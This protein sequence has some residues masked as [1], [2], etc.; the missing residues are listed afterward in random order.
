LGSSASRTIYQADYR[1]TAANDTQFP[2]LTVD[3]TGTRTDYSYDSLKRV[4]T[5]IKKGYNGLQA[6]ITTAIRYDPTGKQLQQAVYSGSLGLTNRWLFDV[7]GRQTSA[8][9]HQGLTTTT[10]YDLG[11][12]RVTTTLPSGATDIQENYLDR[13][14]ASRT[15]TGVVQENH[16]YWLTNYTG[17]LGPIRVIEKVTCGGTDVRCKILGTD[18]FGLPA[19]TETPDFGGNASIVEQRIYY[20]NL[21]TP[22]VVT[23]TG[24]PDQNN[25]LD[26]DGSVGKTTLSDGNWNYP[27]ASQGRITRTLKQFVKE[28]SDWFQTKTNLTYLVDNDATPTVTSV[29]KQ[30]LSGFSAANIQSELEVFVGDHLNS[31]CNT[32]MKEPRWVQPLGVAE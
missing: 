31:G 13:R 11:G 4:R 7:A 16:D 9:D 23:K 20:W 14:L 22:T 17:Q 6:D 19:Y 1:G 10:T 21:N 27:L 3:E 15:G 29:S 18:W 30:R 24:R 26:Y 25:D 32:D 12:R 2:L 5:A 28:G 8:T